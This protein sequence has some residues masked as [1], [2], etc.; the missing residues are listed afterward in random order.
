MARRED[1]GMD[2]IRADLSQWTLHFIHD[3]NWSNQPTD[4]EIDYEQYGGLPYHEVLELN[5]RFDAWRISDEEFPI[6]PDPDALQVL[7]KIITDGHIRSSWA[8]RN[9]RPTIYG[10]RAAVCFTEMPLYALLEYARKRSDYSVRNYAVGV[11][12]TELFAAGGRPVIYGLSAQHAE[13]PA[14]SSMGRTWPRKL[15]PSCGIAESEQYRYVAMSS[16]PNRPIDWSHEREWRWADHQDECSCPGLPVW[17][18]EEPKSFSRVFIVVPTERESERVLER[19]QE[20]YDAGANDFNQLFSKKTLKNTSVISLDVLDSTMTNG[21][22]RHLRLEDVPS[23]RIKIIARPGAPD[24]LVSHVLAVLDEAVKAADRAASEHLKTALRSPDGRHLLDVAGWA[25]L[26]VLDAQVP[27]VSALLQLDE[28]Y[29]VPGVGY[30]IRRIGGLGW[31][32]EQAL[33]IAEASVSAAQKVFEGHFPDVSFGM[34][35]RWD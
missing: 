1:E 21:Q 12:K 3:F 14:D 25:H 34:R 20:L 35:T 2:T 24:C 11:L 5:D 10:P 15:S 32:G 33:S 4:E 19:L 30:I 6:D 23:S 16:K 8:F 31:R 27:L 7:L 29:S 26:M 18:S 13:Q 28:A 9:N 17:V 22:I